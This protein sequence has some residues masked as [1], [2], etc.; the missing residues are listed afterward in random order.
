MTKKSPVLAI[1]YDFDGTLAPGNMQ[2]RDFIP[3]LGLTKKAFW[4]ENKAR[5]QAFNG[6]EIL[7][8]MGLM[9]EKAR[10]ARIPVRREDFAAYGKTLALFPGV[11]GWF[12]R[13]DAYGKARGVKVEHYIISSGI[14]EMIEGTPIASRF[15]EIF[16]SSY[17]YDHHG[18]AEWPALAVNYT[19]KT[20]FLFRINKGCFDI[21]DNKAVNR[22]VPKADRPVPFANMVYIGDGETDVPCFRMVKQ[23]GGHSISVFG[24]K[25]KGG[26]QTS[27]KLLDEGRVNFMAPADYAEGKALDVFMKALVDKVMAD[28]RLVELGKVG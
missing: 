6:D 15:K 19:T 21:S 10:A 7:S 20:Q 2:E 8:Y 28:H 3:R 26:R 22:F 14:R 11:E 18:V 1:C 4:A 13:V 5:A 25:A 9:L 16:A 17:F 24:A 12:D 23:Q 27:Q